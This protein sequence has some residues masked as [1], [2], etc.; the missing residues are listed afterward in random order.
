MSLDRM[1]DAQYSELCSFVIVRLVF[2]V[3][4]FRDEHHAA[5]MYKRSSHR[6]LDLHDGGSEFVLSA[7]ESRDHRV[8]IDTVWFRT[9]QYVTMISAERSARGLD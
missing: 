4:W 5:C 6:S 9:T 8:H 7:K 1:D 3:A 2:C